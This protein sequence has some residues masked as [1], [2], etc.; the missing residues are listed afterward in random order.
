MLAKPI[1]SD[2]QLTLTTLFARFMRPELLGDG[3]YP[4][5]FQTALKWLRMHLGREPVVADLADME[6]LS[7][8]FRFC[9]RRGQSV[10]TVRTYR[11]R[12]SR[13]RNYA[14]D[15]GLLDEAPELPSVVGRPATRSAPQGL[16]KVGTV[17]HYFAHTFRPDALAFRASKTCA[18]YEAAVSWFDRYREGRTA[19]AEIDQTVVVGFRS[20]LEAT[21]LSQPIV[22]RYAGAICKVLVHAGVIS[23][24]DANRAADTEADAARK[25]QGS[26]EW[27]LFEDYVLSRELQESSITRLVFHIRA[28]GRFLGRIPMLADFERQTINGYFAHLEAVGQS[29]ATIKGARDHL[30][31]LWRAAWDAG[32]IEELPRG[33]R[34]IKLNGSVECWTPNEVAALL[35]AADRL[36]VNQDG[37]D[38]LFRRSGGSKRLFFRSLILAGWDAGQRLGDTL[39]LTTERFVMLADGSAEY[40]LQQRK[41]GRMVRFTFRPS[42]VEAIKACCESGNGAAAGRT[43]PWRVATRHHVQG[44]FKRIVAEAQT[45]DGIRYGSF[46]WLRR[47]SVTAREAMQAGFGTLAA[48]HGSSEVTW[49]HYIDTKQLPAAPLPPALPDGAGD[50]DST[51]KEA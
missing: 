2:R 29:R 12:L 27:F 33:V 9:F 21:G 10:A 17:E 51:T 3:S 34:K 43:G 20:F 5:K 40:A 32:H 4:T 30:L 18:H 47:S 41:S 35:R 46:Q 45:V 42:T 36:F 37:T 24:Q 14:V 11:A 22:K 6:G 25:I 15:K 7:G 19:L 16:P 23:N 38:K 31:A 28:F 8:F 44:S 39:A 48:G 49:R 50:L 26:L 13:L 1:E